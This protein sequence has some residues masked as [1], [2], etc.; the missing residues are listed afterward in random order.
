[1]VTTTTRTFRHYLIE[2]DRG[3]IWSFYSTAA[4]AQA[5]IDQSANTGRVV[6]RDFVV[7]FDSPTLLA[8]ND[9]QIA[10]MAIELVAEVVS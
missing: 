4:E 1:M 7:R 8:L 3:S 6:A 5:Q 9:A 2:W 10:K